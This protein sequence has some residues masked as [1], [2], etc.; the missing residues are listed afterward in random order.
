MSIIDELHFIRNNRL[1]QE[2][3]LQLLMFK[4]QTGE[5]KDVKRYVYITEFELNPPTIKKIN[6]NVYMYKIWYRPL[7]EISN[8]IYLKLSQ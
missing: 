2:D 1:Q 7:D 6:Y 3:C 4:L 5:N 8:H